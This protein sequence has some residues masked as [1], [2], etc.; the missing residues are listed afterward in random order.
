MA[1]II[2]P[3]TAATVDGVVGS[4]PISDATDTP[5]ADIRP[6]NGPRLREHADAI[7]GLLKSGVAS[8]VEI[9]RR[10]TEAKRML[11]HRPIWVEWLEQEFGISERHARNF[12]NVFDNFGSLEN[13]SKLSLPVSV[14]YLIA[15]PGTPS[16]VREAVIEHAAKGVEIT[17]NDV[18]EAIASRPTGRGRPRKNAPRSAPSNGSAPPELPD[19]ID[20]PLNA[21]AVAVKNILEPHTPAERQEIC[22]RAIAMLG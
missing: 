8:A 12:M 9:G 17:V 10:L 13:F 5:A 22:Q 21:A 1:D 15:A 3:A 18:K 16:D 11:I 19:K 4:T 6:E 20:L 14:L 2:D 7:R